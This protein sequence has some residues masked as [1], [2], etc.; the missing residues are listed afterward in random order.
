VLSPG[1]SARRLPV[2]RIR[3]RRKPCRCAGL[4][5]RGR[6][7]RGRRGRRRRRRRGRL[8]VIS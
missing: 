1:P 4:R 7:R 5:R 3:R 6:R 8:D 2:L